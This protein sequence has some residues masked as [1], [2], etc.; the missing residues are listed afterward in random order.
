MTEGCC[1]GLTALSKVCLSADHSCVLRSVCSNRWRREPKPTLLTG[2]ELLGSVR[3]NRYPAGRSGCSDPAGPYPAVPA[4]SYSARVL[5][6]EKQ[7]DKKN[8]DYPPHGSISSKAL[9]PGAQVEVTGYAIAS[10]GQLN[11]GLLCRWA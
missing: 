8:Q 6:D 2:C 5:I 4:T 10:G 11:F 9:H 7:Y 3:E 1:Y